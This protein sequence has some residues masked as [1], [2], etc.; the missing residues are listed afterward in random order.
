MLSYLSLPGLTRQSSLAFLPLMRERTYWVYIM[1]SGRNG[2]LYVGV[3]GDIA[4]R[5]HEHRTAAVDGF[6][7]RYDVKLLVHCEAF[8]EVH[9]ALQREKAIKKWPRRWKLDL[10]EES[11][12]DWRD[13]YDDLAGGV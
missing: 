1:A 9:L 3:T 6:T 8:G 12:P 11:N 2:T 5:A 10:I 13:L 4:R 7:S